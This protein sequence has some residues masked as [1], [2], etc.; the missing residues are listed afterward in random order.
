[1]F[2]SSCDA[3]PLFSGI[4]DAIPMRRIATPDEIA[5]SALWLISDHASY[6]TGVV[7][8]VDGGICAS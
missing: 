2:R 5:A 8:P 1:M 6:V 4:V 3:N 7:S